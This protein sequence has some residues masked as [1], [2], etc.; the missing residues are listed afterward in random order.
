[1]INAFKVAR[2]ACR[3]SS[4]SQGCHS[5]KL[6]RRGNVVLPSC[7]SLTAASHGSW[8]HGLSRQAAGKTP[9]TAAMAALTRQLGLALFTTSRGAGSSRQ[10]LSPHVRGAVDLDQHADARVRAHMGL[11][12]R[13]QQ[14]EDR[15]VDRTG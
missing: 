3:E 14:T 13:K 1:M 15:V 2:H 11:L 4:V 9:T 8:R 7:G 12:A 5:N 6:A 10:R